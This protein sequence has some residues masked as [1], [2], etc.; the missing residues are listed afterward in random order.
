MKKVFYYLLLVIVFLVGNYCGVIYALA[1]RH[2]EM[3]LNNVYKY[4]AYNAFYY[5]LSLIVV[6]WL[7]KYSRNRKKDFVLLG[8]MYGIASLFYDVFFVQLVGGVLL[9]IVLLKTY[10]N[11]FPEDKFWQKYRIRE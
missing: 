2:D 10:F 6:L 11:L 8:G 7:L 1:E 5:F 4:H 9:V 3:S